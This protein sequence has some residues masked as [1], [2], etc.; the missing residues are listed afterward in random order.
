[1][2]CSL[3]FLVY[4]FS[5]N[6][7]CHPLSWFHGSLK[8]SSPQFENSLLWRTE[9]YLPSWQQMS[10]AGIIPQNLLDRPMASLS[11]TCCDPNGVRFGVRIY[12]CIC[13]NNLLYLSTFYLW[14]SWL[15]QRSWAL[16]ATNRWA[17][18]A[19][20]HLRNNELTTKGRGSSFW[21]PSLFLSVALWCAG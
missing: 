14:T 4:S 15:R 11:P 6:A 8:G 17:V 2:Q 1:M 3:V 16:H 9:L 20:G 18:L 13:K 7:V 5:F 19:R 10:L 21:K 12:D